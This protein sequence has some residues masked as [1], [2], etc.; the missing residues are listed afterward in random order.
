MMTYREAMQ[1]LP[2]MMI[3][4]EKTGRAQED[5]HTLAEGPA[6]QR[7]GDHVGQRSREV[8]GWSIDPL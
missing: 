3:D 7:E 2:L 1:A 4:P 8:S 6:K 5:V